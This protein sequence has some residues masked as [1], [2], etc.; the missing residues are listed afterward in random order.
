MPASSISEHFYNFQQAISGVPNI[1][2][3]N[4]LTNSFTMAFDLRHIPEDPSTSI[5]SRSGD[6]LRVDLQNLT[7]VNGT[8][9]VWMVL[10]AYTVTS[11][12]V[13]GLELLV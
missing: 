13:W 1:T 12:R 2:R 6:L 11:V 8:T 5:S 9:E 7:S 3:D 4:Y 10:F